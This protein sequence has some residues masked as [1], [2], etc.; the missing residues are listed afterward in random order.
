MLSL[1]SVY[2][3]RT[4][5][6]PNPEK[7][8]GKQKYKRRLQRGLNKSFDAIHLS[9]AKISPPGCGR[10]VNVP[11]LLTYVILTKSIYRRNGRNNKRSEFSISF[12]FANPVALYWLRSHTSHILRRIMKIPM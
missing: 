11:L 4:S 7:S 5:T 6:D 1:L 2:Y 9:T 10:M 3:P 12:T 8:P